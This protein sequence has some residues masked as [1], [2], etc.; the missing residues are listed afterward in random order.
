M[1]ELLVVGAYAPELVGLPDGTVAAAIG[2]GAVDAAAGMGMAL[3]KMG[4]AR[5]VLIG[6]CGVIC[7]AAVGDV[8]VIERAVAVNGA[9]G[10]EIPDVVALSADGDEEMVARVAARGH[11]RAV[12]ACTPGVTVDDRVARALAVGAG[13]KVMVEHMECFAVYRACA[14]AGVPVVA[15]LAVANRIGTGAREEWRRNAQTAEAAAVAAVRK[16]F[17]DP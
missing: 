12:A 6:T 2:I 10:V 17:H 1:T 7:G 14:L 16:L 15:L 3:A 13:V 5:V 9:P 8:V 11:A 4:P